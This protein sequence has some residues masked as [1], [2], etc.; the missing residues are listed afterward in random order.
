MIEPQFLLIAVAWAG[1]TVSQIFGWLEARDE[2]PDVTFNYAYVYA[3]ILS[4]ITSGIAFSMF[5]GT[6]T[7]YWMFI[8]FA[9]GMGLKELSVDVVKVTGGIRNDQP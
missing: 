7:A 5:D 1:A 3:L 2:N 6:V 8:A 9:T 4:M